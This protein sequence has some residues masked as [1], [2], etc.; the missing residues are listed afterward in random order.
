[1][2]SK[3]VM[4]WVS[5]FQNSDDNRLLQET[6]VG[7]NSCA[8]LLREMEVAESFSEGGGEIL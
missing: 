6:E 2:S 1:M 7:Q 4:D 8:K 5:L 3:K